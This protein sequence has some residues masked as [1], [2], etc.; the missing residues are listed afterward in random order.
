MWSN[1]GIICQMCM[2]VVGR[3]SRGG[4]SAFTEDKYDAP[5]V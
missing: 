3:V 5:L 1:G 2:E 4:G